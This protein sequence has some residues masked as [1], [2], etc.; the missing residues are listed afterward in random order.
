MFSHWLTQLNILDTIVRVRNQV[1]KNPPPIGLVQLK[2]LGEEKPGRESLRP[3]H[4]VQLCLEVNW[5]IK[6]S[7][8]IPGCGVS[9]CCGR[10]YFVLSSYQ[11]SPPFIK[12]LST[13]QLK[14]V[15]LSSDWI[16]IYYLYFIKWEAY[17]IEL[18]L[19]YIYRPL[20]VRPNVTLSCGHVV[21]YAQIKPQFSWQI[22]SLPTSSVL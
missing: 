8:P 17:L 16:Y 10:G 19:H 9:R 15:F 1:K 4:D 14:R 11:S 6:W 7:T 3:V 20:K 13:W 2:L 22:W 21:H 18:R 12:F 5:R